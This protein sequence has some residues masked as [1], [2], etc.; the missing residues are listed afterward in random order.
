MLAQA[1]EK[2]GRERGDDHK[3]ETVEEKYHV[4]GIGEQVIASFIKLQ[5]PGAL[6]R[7]D[8]HH[9]PSITGGSTPP[10]VGNDHLL[11]WS[12]S[13]PLNHGDCWV[14]IPSRGIKAK[15]MVTTSNNTLVNVADFGD[16]LEIETDLLAA[17]R[18]PVDDDSSGGEG[19]KAS[20]TSAST[21]SDADVAP[22]KRRRRRSYHK[23]RP[24]RKI[25]LRSFSSIQRCS[26]S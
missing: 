4:R 12:S 20:G 13:I 14:E 16:V 6:G 15:L 3:V 9:A 7:Q 21:E 23:P 8:V 25:H 24:S 5:V 22:E 18:S 1:G 17:K 26:Q 19:D 2:Q 11:P 10:L